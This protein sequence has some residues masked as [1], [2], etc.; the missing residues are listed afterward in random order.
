VRAVKPAASEGP[1]VVE[2]PALAGA[3]G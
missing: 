1:E 3:A 2:A